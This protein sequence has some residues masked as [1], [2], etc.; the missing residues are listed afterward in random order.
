MFEYRLYKD[1]Q[2]DVETVELLKAKE[3]Y[4]LTL[5]QAIIYAN[6]RFLTSLQLFNKLKAKGFLKPDINQAIDYLKDLKVIDDQMYADDFILIKKNQGYGPLYIKNKLYQLGIEK[7][8]FYSEQEQLTI[9]KPKYEKGL[10]KA[11]NKNQ[12]NQKFQNKMQS[13]GFSLDLIKQVLQKQQP[14]DDYE[15]LVK[16]Y[17]KYHTKYAKKYDEY[18]LKY[19]LK[20]KLLQL[21]YSAQAIQEVMEE[22]Y[23]SEIY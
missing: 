14:Q 6:A 11:K 5:E 4:Y 23:S 10:I 20:N 1:Q 3:S 17:E 8:V 21:G 16:D 19:Y 13:Q 2:I 22:G 15:K 7:D 18:K 12:F 9:L